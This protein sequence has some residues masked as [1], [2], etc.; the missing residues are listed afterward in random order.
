MELRKSTGFTISK[1]LTDAKAHQNLMMKNYRQSMRP[2]Y[3]L[4]VQSE[5]T[6]ASIIKNETSF[7]GSDSF[8][9]KG[10]Y[11]GPQISNMMSLE[12]NLHLLSQNK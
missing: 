2:D 7:N 12:A 3:T 9:K 6:Q 1:Q 10:S 11:I 5:G 8:L 4:Q